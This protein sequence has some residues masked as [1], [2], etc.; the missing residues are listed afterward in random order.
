MS[1]PAAQPP[2]ESWP[3]RD[4][5]PRDEPSSR[6]RRPSRRYSGTEDPAEQTAE[7]FFAWDDQ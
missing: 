2:G 1:R 6:G 5:P 3:P 4:Q 7:G